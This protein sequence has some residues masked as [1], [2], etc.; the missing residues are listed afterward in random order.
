M[1]SAVGDFSFREVF[2]TERRAI[3]ER[4]K[5]YMQEKFDLYKT[6]IVIQHVQLKE[7]RPA[8][9][10]SEPDTTMLL[11]PFNPTDSTGVDSVKKVSDN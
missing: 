10:L 7:A 2:Q 5:N 6:G 8:L 11:K 3:A 4:A 1:R 9:P